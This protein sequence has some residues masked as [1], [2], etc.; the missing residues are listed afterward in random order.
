MRLRP[1]TG[2][3]SW[4]PQTTRPASAGCSTSR[5]SCAPTTPLPAK[6]ERIA[7]AVA[8]SLG[9]GAVAI[10]LHRPAWDDFEVV[11]LHGLELPAALELP[12]P[13]RRRADAR[14]P[15][16]RPG[17]L[18]GGPRG[19]RRVRRARRA[20][21]R[22]GPGG[23]RRGAAQ[24]GARADA[25]RLLASRRPALRRLGA[26]GG[27][28]GRTRCARLRARDR[29]ARRPRSADRYRPVAVAGIDLTH[30]DLQLARP[31]SPRSTR[32]FDPAFERE[33]CYLL[34]RDG[35]A[36]A[37]RLPSPPRTPRRGTATGRARGTGTG[38]SRPG[39]RQ[40]GRSRASSGWTTRTTG[41]SPSARVFRRCGCSRTR[42]QRRSPPPPATRRCARRRS[43]TARCSPRRPPGSSPSGST[44][45]SAPGTTPR[46]AC[47][48]IPDA[49]VIGHE[50][51]WI[52]GEPSAPLPRALPRD[53][54][55]RRAS[56][57]R[58]STTAARTARSSTCARPPR[59]CTTPPAPST[60]VIAVIEDITERTRA[61]ADLER[62][63]SELEALHATTLE[64]LDRL[65]VGS[66]LER[67]VAQAGELLRLGQRLPLPRRPAGRTSSSL[68][69]GRG[70]F[71]GHK[72]LAARR[73]A[74]A[75]AGGCGTR[76]R[77]WPSTTT[78]TWRVER[79]ALRR[80]GLPWPARASRSAAG[81]EVVGVLGVASEEQRRTFGEAELA[82]LDASAVSP[83]SRS[84]TRGLYE[85]SGRAR[86]S[87]ARSSRAR[88]T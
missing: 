16:G 88:A 66:T 81:D 7:A 70:F 37:R 69:I 79:R 74:R 82:L 47:S 13:Q 23:G 54:R 49:E 8:S 2:R 52:R 10:S 20:G 80:P 41:C 50:P 26:R 11:A 15:R 72:G 55:A 44:A 31:R 30:A 87:T 64:L 14:D 45:G 3:G 38:S 24:R 62:R 48:A 51:P 4:R 42:P 61:A 21:D 36:R 5:A 65:D 73:A 6:L 53:R 35:R 56:T 71:S 75:S 39:A 68:T 12:L 76:V 9:F 19:A 85:D 67:I 28:R 57:R 18:A 43:C 29:R 77:R 25:R 60:G 58:S 78:A 84:R 63:N 22:V 40:T 1:I 59:P 17:G 34:A 46:G 33:G 86:S 32:I 27:V 83:R